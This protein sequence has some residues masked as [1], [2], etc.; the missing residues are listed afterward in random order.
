[1]IAV[2]H[3]F[4]NVL[5]WHLRQL[6]R[7]DVFQVQKKFEIIVVLIIAYDPESNRVL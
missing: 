7:K 3:Q 4:D 1:M 5:L 6:S 2:K